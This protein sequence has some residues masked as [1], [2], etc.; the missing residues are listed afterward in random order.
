MAE[1]KFAG[2]DGPVES[3]EI[4]A[5]Y[6]GAPAYD[7]VRVGRLGVYYRDGFKIR[8]LAYDRLERAFIRVQE[9]RGRL[10]CGQANFA[11][12]R[13]VLVS[14]GKEYQDVMSEKEAIMDQ[15]LAAI[16]AAAPG[17]PIGVPAR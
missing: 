16:A 15:A 13:L 7:R 3:P 12:Y 5:D 1:K 11:Y 8:F 9:V 4:R 10:C 17:L 6:D 14:G 2:L